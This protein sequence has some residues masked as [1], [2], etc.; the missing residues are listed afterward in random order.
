MYENQDN[1]LPRIFLSATPSEFYCPVGNFDDFAGEN[2]NK[3]EKISNKGTTAT[4]PA[5][6]VLNFTVVTKT[7]YN[8]LLISPAVHVQSGTAGG[9]GH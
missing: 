5:A 9:R 2:W 3:S 8:L 1:D 7:S 4:G 6:T